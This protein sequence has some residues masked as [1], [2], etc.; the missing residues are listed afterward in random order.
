L[1]IAAIEGPASAI[2]A[3]KARAASEDR[4]TVEV[5]FVPP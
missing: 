1:T 5:I 2:A 3:V 4:K